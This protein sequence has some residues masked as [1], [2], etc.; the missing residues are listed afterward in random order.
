VVLQNRHLEQSKILEI[1]ENEILNKHKDI[2]NI[3]RENDDLKEKF[4][5]ST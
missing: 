2:D 4:K 5:V 3:R 1:K